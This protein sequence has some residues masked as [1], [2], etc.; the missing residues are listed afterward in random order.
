MRGDLDCIRHH[1]AEA[2]VRAS[3]SIDLPGQFGQVTW[4]TRRCSGPHHFRLFGCPAT[5]DG[6]N[7]A[8]PSRIR[9]E[10]VRPVSVRS[11]RMLSLRDRAVV[12]T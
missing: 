8:T 6:G 11:V 1:H 9:I 5:A 7:V 10:E 12:P 3:P 2:A 4:D